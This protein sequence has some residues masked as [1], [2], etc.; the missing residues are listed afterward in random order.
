MKISVLMSSYN[1]AQYIEKAIDS[2]INQTYENWELIIVDDG[3]LDNSVEIIKSYE[4]KD[5]RIK[6][7]Q[8]NNCQNRG[9]KET[10]LLGLK[11]ANGDWIAFLESDDFW[12]PANLEE[13]IKIIKKYPDNKLIFNKVNFV[14]EDKIINLN[15][16]IKTQE[17][18][19][20]MQFPKNMFYDFGTD[21]MVLTFSCA[22]VNKEILLDSYFKT[23]I[24]CFLDWCLWIH[25]AYKND[26]YYID[27][28][29]TNWRLHRQSYIKKAQKFI[30]HLV[31][32]QAYK[33]IYRQ[34]KSLKLLFFIVCTQ[35]MALFVI[36][37]FRFIKKFIYS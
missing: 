30:F 5:S 12:E 33:D 19:S 17:K 7:L 2:V 4:K 20:K 35:I 23:S 8:H 24:D 10:L 3:S 26:F 9:L 13:K 1:Y 27:E 36:K 6:L 11:N 18:L 15:K 37:P 16:F 22:M 28:V 21:N 31:Q 34:E 25:L 14:V 32:I 29:L